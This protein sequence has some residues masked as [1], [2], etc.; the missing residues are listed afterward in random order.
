MKVKQY[1]IN[2]K[3]DMLAFLG[4]GL[5]YFYEEQQELGFLTSIAAV[6][7]FLDIPR[8][9]MAASIR[10][11]FFDSRCRSVANIQRLYEI[12][13]QNQQHLPEMILYVEHH[14][15]LYVSL[16]SAQHSLEEVRIA[17]KRLCKDIEIIQSVYSN[18]YRDALAYRSRV[19]VET[20]HSVLRPAHVGFRL[21]TYLDVLRGMGCMVEF[22]LVEK[23]K[24]QNVCE[25]I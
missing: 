7:R 21:T 5:K 25:S 12:Y 2:K 9:I 11:D 16:S 17:L 4:Q 23:M 1:L 14:Q 15:G 10:G 3:P 20:V 18:G 8:D 6:C 24:E 19:D 13:H 22:K